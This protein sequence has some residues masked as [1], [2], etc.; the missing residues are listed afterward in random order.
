M[1]KQS[2][3]MTEL[4]KQNNELITQ[5]EAREQYLIELIE[6]NNEL[7]TE[8]EEGD[9]SSPQYLDMDE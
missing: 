7:I 5:A 6:A 3:L 8:H 9:D 1:S 4:I 2:E